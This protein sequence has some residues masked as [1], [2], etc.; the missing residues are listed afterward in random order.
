MSQSAASA[1][2]GLLSARHTADCY[3]YAGFTAAPHACR[4][5]CGINF[6][7]WATTALHTG[8]RLT[9]KNGTAWTKT[10]WADTAWTDTGNHALHEAC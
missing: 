2:L 9:R 1:R 4:G 7:F 3:S 5:H 10:A 6:N 8:C